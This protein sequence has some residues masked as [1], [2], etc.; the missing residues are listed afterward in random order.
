MNRKALSASIGA[1]A[2]SIQMGSPAP[3]DV[4]PDENLIN[5]LWLLDCRLRADDRAGMSQLLEE[6]DELL[7][8]IKGRLPECLPDALADRQASLTDFG[9]DLRRRVLEDDDSSDDDDSGD[10]TFR[11]GGID[12]QY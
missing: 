6:N 9:D 5:G 3:A 2:I 4:H 12:H 7:R 11:R 10:V 1:L 8:L